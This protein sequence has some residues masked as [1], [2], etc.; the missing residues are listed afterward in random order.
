VSAT[1]R[2]VA[3]DAL[4]FAGSLTGAGSQHYTDDRMIGNVT[5]AF[6]LLF[7]KYYWHPY[8]EWFQVTLDGVT[9]T[10]TTDVFGSILDFEDVISVH[11]DG[12][13][14]PLPILPFS[15]NPFALGA[16]TGVPRYYTALQATNP[17]YEEKKLL[18]YPLTA[19][20]L[21]N[22]HARIHPRP[23]GAWEEEDEMFLD[24]DMLMY[25]A[26]YMEFIA[27]DSNPA[28]ATTCQNLMEMK[29]KDIM[30]SFA[31]QPIPIEG[32]ASIPDRWIEGR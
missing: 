10:I 29:F 22:V 19:T 6:N 26:A 23:D 12:Y 7:K 21:V 8:R 31:S 17:N 27:D 14:N 32:D 3:D 28:A 11:I 13:Q 18:F 20:G 30:N 9:G 1:I 5:R 15:K 16:S 25:G 2:Q 24:K 4:A